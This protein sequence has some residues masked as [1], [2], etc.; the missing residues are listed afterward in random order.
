MRTTRMKFKALVAS[1]LGTLAACV[2][3][4][5]AQPAQ[6]GTTID[7]A[8]ILDPYDP[9]PGIGFDHC[10]DGCGHH[11][12]SRCGRVRHCWDDCHRG[13]GDNCH[14]GCGDR[15]GERVR[16]DRDCAPRRCGDDCDAERR[17]CAHDCNTNRPP[18][19]GDR[20]GGDATNYPK[21]AR[22]C[23]SGNCFDA[24][25]YEHRWRDGSR[26][27]HEWLRRGASQRD[28][29]Q[30]DRDIDNGD[31]S[32]WNPPPPPPPPPPVDDKKKH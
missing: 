29:D 23:L 25:R 16:C 27:G 3:L 13:C 11:C 10:G 12:Y 18:C 1:V 6:A 20:C 9:V 4:L 21:P 2:M 5:A 19:D 26:K 8:V 15:C 22:P 17:P 7:D 24:E 32:A 14:R 31:D 30:S 28:W